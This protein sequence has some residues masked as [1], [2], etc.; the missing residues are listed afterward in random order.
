MKYI[1][2]KLTIEKVSLRNIARD[3]EH[4]PTAILTIN[5]KKILLILKKILILSIL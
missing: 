5:W 2:K 3:I 4:L 1:N